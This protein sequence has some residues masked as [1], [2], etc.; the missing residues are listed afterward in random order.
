MR[1]RI[2]SRKHCLEPTLKLGLRPDWVS[3]VYDLGKLLPVAL[4]TI[5]EAN[6]DQATF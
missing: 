3:T 6:R 1:S 4:W 5:R 2:A